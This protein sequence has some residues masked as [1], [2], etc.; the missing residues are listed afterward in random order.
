V[1]AGLQH[2]LH[3]YPAVLVLLMVHQHAPSALLEN[4]VILLGPVCVVLVLQVPSEPL[5]DYHLVRHVLLVLTVM[6]LAQQDVRHAHLVIIQPLLVQVVVLY[7]LLEIL[8]I[9]LVQLVASDV[10]PVIMLE[11]TRQ[12]HVISV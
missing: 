5:Q 1:K 3:V 12:Q 10:Q 8:Q 4:I 6:F 9:Q 11:D 2:V 7:V